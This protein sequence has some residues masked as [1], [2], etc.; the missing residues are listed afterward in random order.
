MDKIILKPLQY[1]GEENI[2]MYFPNNALL[3]KAVR[4]I[5]KARWTTT[6]KCWYVPHSKQKYNEIYTAFKGIASIDESALHPSLPEKKKGV[7]KAI[8]KVSKKEKTG[9]I[10]MSGIHPVNAH[11]IPALKQ[12]LV[13]K[14]YSASTIKTYTNE[15]AVFLRAIQHHEADAFNITRIKDYL[16]YCFEK[17]DLSENTIHSRMNALKFYF[18]QVLGK[19]K[20]FW[21]IPRPKKRIILP[22]VIS[23]EKIIGGLMA[24]E[25]MKHKTLLL[26]AYSAGMRVSEVIQLKITDIDSDRMQITINEAKGKKDRVVTLSTTILELLR[27]YYKQYRPKFWLFEGQIVN[28]HYSTRSAQL[29]FKNAYKKLGLPASCSFHSLRH[30]YAT[31]LLENG[32]DISYIQKLMGHNDIKTTLRYTHVSKKDISKIESPLDKIMRKKGL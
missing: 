16:Q 30:S 27:E 28:E 6:H 25:N 1:N 24:V 29:I 8:D 18:E 10:K 7:I 14:A 4:S 22:K 15:V 21:E 23:E 9:S 3:N 5:K 26:L 2:A 31:H 11:V 17:L 12:V 13:L 19:E 20:L 32:T